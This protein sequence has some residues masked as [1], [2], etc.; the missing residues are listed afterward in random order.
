M[1]HRGRLLE[2]LRRA[3]NGPMIDE[4]DFER[5]LIT[6]TVKRL[7]EKYQIKF[8]R[9]SIINS[10]DDLADRLFR[11]GLNCS[12][13]AMFCQNTTSRLTLEEYKDA[14]HCPSEA[15]MR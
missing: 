7:I 4:K 15:I 9:S 11:R 5:N 6:P 12:Q 8:D 13:E 3:E 14:L 10:N 2:V 1:K